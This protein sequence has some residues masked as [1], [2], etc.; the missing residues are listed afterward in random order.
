MDQRP[1]YK[2]RYTKLDKRENG[3]IILNNFQNRTSIVQAL[4][5]TINKWDLMN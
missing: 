2:T 3:G 4:K 5:S 1:Q